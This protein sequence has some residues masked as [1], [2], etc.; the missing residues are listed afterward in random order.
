MKHGRTS[1]RPMI[2]V[3]ALSRYAANHGRAGRPYG[4]LCGINYTSFQVSADPVRFAGGWVLTEEPV[5]CRRCLDA[6]ERL[7]EQALHDEA[8]ISLVTEA[9]QRG[10]AARVRLFRLHWPAMGRAVA[11]LLRHRGVP[12]GDGWLGPATEVDR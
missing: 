9:A 12:L 11:D 3:H 1:D 4:A 10:P 2:A 6:L 7:A 5:G 8:A